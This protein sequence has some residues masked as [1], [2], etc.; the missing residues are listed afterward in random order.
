MRGKIALLA[1][2]ALTLPAVGVP[3][4]AATT[5][6]TLPSSDSSAHFVVHYD[7]AT[8]SA[9]YV[10]EALTDF[11]ESYSRLV[12]GGGGVPNAGLRAPV[13]DDLRGGDAR[14]DVYLTAP[15]GGG[16]QVRSDNVP[17]PDPL[18]DSGF[19]LMDPTLSRPSF[20]FRA[21]HEF[22]HLIQLAYIEDIGL[23]TEGTANWASDLALPDVDPLDSQFAAPFLPLD[24]SYSSWNAQPCGNGYRQW[25]FFRWLS[26]HFG[27][28]FVHRLWQLHAAA[29][30]A[31]PTQPIT[32]ET[33]RDILAKAI[34]DE[35]GDA[36]LTSM[37]ADYAA[38]LWDPAVWS[39]TAVQS[40]HNRFGPP[41]ATEVT[42]SRGAPSTGPRP[43]LV[44]HLATKYIRFVPG[45]SPAVGDRIR[46]RVTPGVGVS[47]PRL[48][49]AAGPGVAR[50][51][52]QL[53]PAGDGAY[54]AVV[55]L[56]SGD[57]VLPLTN[58]TTTDALTFTYSAEF[59]PA[60]VEIRPKLSRLSISPK[61][62]RPM[63]KG[64][65]VTTARKRAGGARLAFEVTVPA[66]MKFTIE[67][68]ASGRVVGGTCV[69][70][71]RANRK[72]KGCTRYAK[73]TSVNVPGIGVG[74]RVLRLTGRRNARKVLPAG[75]YRLVAIAV[76]AKGVRS[77]RAT[78]TFSI[79]KATKR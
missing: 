13:K 66:T 27:D 40:I 46:V 15:S 62:F 76:D 7:P 22:M 64:P 78:S 58:N 48:L 29:F 70:P 55:P 34:A 53:S 61:R 52:A 50:S 71:T 79:K 4:A 10:S 11:E 3:A 38:A 12:V 14:I 49:S 75:D 73:V 20:R 77:N 43:V 31:K 51:V 23:L 1:V 60:P 45:S 63:T 39:T 36:T 17:H 59:L 8:A 68:G 67:R 26:E 32:P 16:G 28:G 2:V 41:V 33:D 18:V 9:G 44:D 57:V 72:K 74:T 56:A 65:A 69:K 21:A 19:I 42:M 37:Y 35:P 54:E 24:C 6:P 30:T 25:L 47:P 5:R